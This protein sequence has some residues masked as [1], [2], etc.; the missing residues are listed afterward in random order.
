[1][2]DLSAWLTDTFVNGPPW[3]EFAKAMGI[4]EGSADKTAGS[5]YVV[6]VYRAAPRHRDPLEKSLG[7]TAPGD[8]S[9]GTVLMQHLDGG[10][11]QFL[12]VVRYSSWQDFATNEKNGMADTLKP[13]EGWMQVREHSSYHNDTVTG[14]IAP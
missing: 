13:A 4:D 10:S 8:T 11:W 3:P 2:R 12:G 14:R 7:Q 5:V 9:A 1:M 6:S